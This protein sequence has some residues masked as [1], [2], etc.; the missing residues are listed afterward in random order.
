MAITLIEIIDQY[1]K[2][3]NAQDYIE[4]IAQAN[5][6]RQLYNQRAKRSGQ[7]EIDVE[8]S[9]IHLNSFLEKYEED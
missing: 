5:A 3:S 2:A 7:P 4:C 6:Y 8:D 9:Y 1:I